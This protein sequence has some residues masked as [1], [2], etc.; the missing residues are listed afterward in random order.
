MSSEVWNCHPWYTHLETGINRQVNKIGES[1][2]EGGKQNSTPR[3]LKV[4]EKTM[5][6]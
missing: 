2:M 3:K 4:I 6:L 5:Q 1:I